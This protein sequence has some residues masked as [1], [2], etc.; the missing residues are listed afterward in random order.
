[1]MSIV[2]KT[3]DEGMTGLFGGKRVSKDSVRIHTYGTVDELNAVL[4]VA[5]A[6]E[7]IPAGTSNQL[8]RLQ[9]MLFRVGGD[10]ATP[11]DKAAKEDRVADKHIEEVE[12]WIEALETS[13]PQQKAFLLPGGSKAS[14]LLHLARTICRRA[15]RHVVGLMHEEEINPAIRVFLNRTGDYLF[16]AARKANVNAGIGE[17]EVQY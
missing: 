12:A 3:G 5:L 4:G 7:G 11:L 6:E 17:T 2:T 15:E 8:L 13:L 14:S 10:L 9:H 16:L 1:M